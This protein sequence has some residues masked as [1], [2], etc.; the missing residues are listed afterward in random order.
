MQT[1]ARLPVTFSHGAGVYLYDSAG[2]RYLDGL[3]GIAVCGLGH[4]HPAVT[5]AITAQADKLLHTSNL[6]GIDAQEELAS[7]LTGVA[8]MDSCFFANSGAEANEAAIKLARL[9]GHNRGVEKPAIVVLEGAFHGRTLATLSATG[10]RKIQ[11]G[12]EPL[13]AGFIRAPR[14]DIDALRQIAANNPGVVAFL[15]E[16]IQGEG[17]VNPLDP[18]YLQAV[19]EICDAQDW[20][21]MLDEVQ[22]G[23]GRT[24]TY[25]AYQGMDFTPDVVTTAKGLGNG[26]PIGACLARGKA[27]QVLG[28][29]QH[30]S[31]YGG[32]PLACSAALA[33]VN[34]IVGEELADNAAAMGQVI[35]D[36]LRADP[37]VAGKIAEIRGAGLMLGIDLGRD[38]AGLVQRA[39]DEG[40][41]INVTAGSTIRLLPPLT[42]NEGEA[43]E[44]ARGVAELIRALP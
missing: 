42:I 12:F 18:G 17:G 9:Y 19:R 8:G 37:E 34:T 38:C 32:N 5:A 30:G 43:R 44:L 3:S 22:T 13:V 39:L 27:A 26:V 4:A 21:L 15:A 24:G 29:G 41:L 10:N 25:F 16:P 1:Y 14:N 31:T 2:R 36:T 7:T 23:N 28:A 40:L 6:Y 35:R 20:L 11:A 33:V